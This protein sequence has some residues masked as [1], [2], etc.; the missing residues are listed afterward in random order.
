MRSTLYMAVISVL[1]YNPKIK[2][3]YQR[4]CDN[5]K[6]AKV[7]ITVCIHKLIIILNAILKQQ[8]NDMISIFLFKHSC[9]HILVKVQ[10][11]VG[12]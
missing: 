9:L 11:H 7:T 5:G 4:L 3:F 1:R 12:L 8:N 10:T 6:K 2:T